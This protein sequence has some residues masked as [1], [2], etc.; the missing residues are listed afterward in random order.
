MAPSSPCKAFCAPAGVFTLPNAFKNS[1]SGVVKGFFMGLGLVGLVGEFWSKFAFRGETSQ[2][3]ANI[4]TGLKSWLSM[5][6]V[7]IFAFSANSPAWA[8]MQIKGGRIEIEVNIII[9][10][11]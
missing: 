4:K 2:N 5:A 1:L 3:F 11:K 10:N 7:C 6:Y 9:S 8:Q